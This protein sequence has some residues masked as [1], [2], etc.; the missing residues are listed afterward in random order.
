MRYYTLLRMSFDTNIYKIFET[1]DSQIYRFVVP[2]AEKIKPQKQHQNNIAGINFECPKCKQ[3]FLIQANLKP[4]QK[5]RPN[6]LPFP[7]ETNNFRCPKCGTESNLSPARLQIEAQSGKKVVKQNGVKMKNKKYNF[8]IIFEK[9]EESKIEFQNEY[10]DDLENTIRLN[11]EIKA[12]QDFVSDI[13]NP[14]F[15]TFTR[16]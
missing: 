16:A 12:L 14:N 10:K 11:E 1:I 4:N 13:N 9:L 7:V 2:P 5:L 6:H 15:E 8:E 3:H